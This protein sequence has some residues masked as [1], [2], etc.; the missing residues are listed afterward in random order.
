MTDQQTHSGQYGTELQIMQHY[1]D[2]EQIVVTT[3]TRTAPPLTSYSVSVPV[4]RLLAMIDAAYPDAMRT[5]TRETVDTALALPVDRLTELVDR[6]V[7][8]FGGPATD[9]ELPAYIAEGILED[10]AADRAACAGPCCSTEDADIDEPVCDGPCCDP[11]HD[12][13]D[14]PHDTPD[15]AH[16]DTEDDDPLLFDTPYERLYLLER[17]ATIYPRLDA[18]QALELAA[19]IRDPDERDEDEVPRTISGEVLP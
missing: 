19:W 12:D 4:A 18:G 9:P 5:Y 14:E 6:S 8:G 2:P 3:G 16:Y 10:L 1:A 7:R 15:G 11:E 13:I 17:L